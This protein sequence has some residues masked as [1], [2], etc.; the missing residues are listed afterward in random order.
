MRLRIKE[1]AKNQPNF[2]EVKPDTKAKEGDLGSLDYNATVDGK[3]FKAVGGSTTQVSSPKVDD[4]K[5]KSMV[6]DFSMI[7][8]FHGPFYVKSPMM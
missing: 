7:P 3:D 8:E 4:S 2:K 5:E 1:I 6:Y